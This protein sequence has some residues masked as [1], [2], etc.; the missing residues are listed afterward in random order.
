MSSARHLPVGLAASSRAAFRSSRKILIVGIDADS[1]TVDAALRSVDAVIFYALSDYWRVRRAIAG[2]AC[3]VIDISHCAWTNEGT[4]WD[5]ACTLVKRIGRSPFLSAARGRLVRRSLMT[6]ILL[7]IE[8]ARAR[9]D[10]VSRLLGPQATATAVGMSRFEL[11]ALRRHTS[12]V[13]VDSAQGS[14][15]QRREPSLAR[16]PRRGLPLTGFVQVL[17]HWM[18]TPKRRRCE[19]LV[20]RQSGDG[21]LAALYLWAPVHRV[22][23]SSTIEALTE[24]GWTVIEVLM[25]P[26]E[27]SLQTNRI[28]SIR[29]LRFIDFSA[30]DSLG[31]LLARRLLGGTVMR[32]HVVEWATTVG[33]EDYA[34]AIATHVADLCY[35]S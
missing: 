9:A 13:E 23:Y 16:T 18:D 22:L 1:A 29:Q 12:V 25:P 31:Q 20:R 27:T 30:P 24:A 7:Q 3:T 35:L 10:E 28:D 15:E 4:A 5:H 32:R 17:R 34:E 14:S 2:R 21:P 26:N 8:M 33:L 19:S 6:G 11:A